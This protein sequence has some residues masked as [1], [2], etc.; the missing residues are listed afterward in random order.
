MVSDTDLAYW[1]N[2]AAIAGFVVTF[3]GAFVGIFGYWSY[4]R[5][6]KKKTKALVSYLKDKKTQASAGKKG[7]QTATHLIR[8]VGLTEDEISKNQFRKQT[9]RALGRQRRRR[10]GRHIIFRI[11]EITDDFSMMVLEI[12]KCS[13]Q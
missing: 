7:Q 11:Q 2:I 4:R 9:Y 10:K 6:W 1:A 12:H 5:S 13:P 3:I 8:Y